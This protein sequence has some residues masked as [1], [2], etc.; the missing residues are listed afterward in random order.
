MVLIMMKL[1]SNIIYKNEPSYINIFYSSYGFYNTLTI[2]M[3]N[4][5]SIII[6][7][8]IMGKYDGV[9]SDNK[10][11][12]NQIK[13]NMNDFHWSND[14]ININKNIKFILHKS[15]YS[16][17]FTIT[18]DTLDIDKDKIEINPK[19]IIP[20]DS[21]GSPT[22]IIG[23]DNKDKLKLNLSDD[24]MTLSNNMLYCNLGPGLTR[25]DQNRITIA[26]ASC[27]LKFINNQ[28]CFD[29][30][31]LID[32]FNCI[33][34]DDKQRLRLDY[35][36]EDF[37]KDSTGKIY[38]KLYNKHLKK[39]QNGVELNIDNDTIKFDTNESKLI[40]S[41]DKY[42]VPQYSQ[43]G[44]I[45]LDTNKKLK[46][47]INNYVD[48]NIGS[49]VVMNT[50]NKID[51]D[52]VNQQSG[53][54][55]FEKPNELAIRP[56]PYFTRDSSGHLL[57]VVNNDH[58][59]NLNNHKLNLDVSPPLTYVNKK[60]TLDY[61]AYFKITNN[62]LD[63]DIIKLTTDVVIPSTGLK[64][65]NDRT[66]SIDTS[67]LTSLINVSALSGLKIVG[68]EIIVDE[69]LMSSNLFHLSSNSPIKRRP[70]NYYELECDRV[71]ID[72]DFVTGALM[73]KDTYVPSVVTKDYIKNKV[74][75]ES[76]FKDMLKFQ[77]PVIL[78]RGGLCYWDLNNVSHVDKTIG[79]NSVIINKFQNEKH[80]FSDYYYFI[81]QNN[82]TYHY[83]HYSFELF[84]D[85]INDNYIYFNNTTQKIKY[86]DIFNEQQNL[87][88]FVFN[89]VI[90]PQKK[91]VDLNSTL[92]MCET[93]NYIKLL[94]DNK[95]II[96]KFG[97]M[98]INYSTNPN[99]IIVPLIS[100]MLNKKT[101]LT[102][103]YD[104]IYGKVLI[105]LNSQI[106]YENNNIILFVI[107]QGK[108]NLLTHKYHDFYLGNNG[109][110][111]QP[112][113]GRMYDFSMLQNIS[114]DEAINLH[115]Y[116]K[117]IHNI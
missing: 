99:E 37:I 58:G 79:T 55:Y 90:E 17:K 29:N 57:P 16:D 66:I 41:I 91:S 53:E 23:V 19:S 110:N 33:K 70:N 45:Y 62:K 35:S 69:P 112:Y 67:V 50:N 20:I 54:I 32:S 59:L 92:M 95:G 48:D 2:N 42:L 8:I 56:S 102:F 117:Y 52:I 108:D 116:Y 10:D 22:S 89:F 83:K 84:S 21:S 85:V 105:I 1:Y 64:L 12:E 36:S 107:E 76:Y 9:I 93:D 43:N 5:I 7:Y 68:N 72:S 40:S 71:T 98:L 6:T 15:Q 14:M 115:E 73:V 106:V 74:I 51:I 80:L 100:T 96:F 94:Y 3:V 87:T 114:R 78:K 82:P 11:F 61:N 101:I 24:F 25:D 38:L 13:F 86:T 97:K 77:G 111:S 39:T 63:I 27:N 26:L 88:S 81:T 18:N 46:I 4:I 113:N 34:L 30:S 65:N 47:N 60:L 103:F 109:N 49:K 31:S 75:N 44:D 28:L 104:N